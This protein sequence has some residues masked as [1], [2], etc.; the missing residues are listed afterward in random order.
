MNRASLAVVLI[1][2]AFIA[3]IAICGSVFLMFFGMK[4]FPAFFGLIALQFGIGYIMNKNHDHRMLEAQALTAPIEQN[5]TVP[6]AY[7]Q[8]PNVVLLF[9]DQDNKFTCAECNQ[10]NSLITTYTTARITLPVNAQMDVTKAK[11][12]V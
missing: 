6:C 1:S 11:K 12:E 8:R 7:C 3:G 10:T 5:I 4:F 9:T 2:A